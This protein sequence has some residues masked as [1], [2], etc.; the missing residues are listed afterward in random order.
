M[1]ADGVNF[2]VDMIGVLVMVGAFSERGV[3]PEEATVER[4]LGDMVGGGV[5]GGGRDAATPWM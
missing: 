5:W 1:N 3:V 2:G 4:I